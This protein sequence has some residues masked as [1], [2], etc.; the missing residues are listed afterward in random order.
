MSFKSAKTECNTV[1]YTKKS[2][3]KGVWSFIQQARDGPEQG[4]LNITFI[5]KRRI[6]IWIWFKQDISF[7]SRFKL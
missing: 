2:G 6:K 1:I 7:M 4:I 5:I 3:E